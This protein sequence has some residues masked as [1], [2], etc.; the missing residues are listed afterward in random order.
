MVATTGHSD[1]FAHLKLP[2]G[3]W[4]AWPTIAPC[5]QGSKHAHMHFL[6]PT[7][8]EVGWVGGGGQTSVLATPKQRSGG[9]PT[10]NGAFGEFKSQRDVPKLTQANL[11]GDLF[12]DHNITHRFDCV[13]NTNEAI[14]A[15][16]SG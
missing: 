16:H 7:R 14:N 9:G 12:I 6:Q 11:D 15:L 10:H 1:W 2:L 3:K 8:P 4:A 5:G 13:G